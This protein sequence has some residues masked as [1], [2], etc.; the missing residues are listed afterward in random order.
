MKELTKEQ[1]IILLKI[2]KARITLAGELQR[3]YI[4]TRDIISTFLKDSE[5]RLSNNH[6]H[7]TNILKNIINSPFILCD[8]DNLEMDIKKLLPNILKTRYDLE[9]EELYS[10]YNNGDITDDELLDGKQMLKFCYYESSMDGKQIFKNG[11]VKS[12]VN[13]KI[14]CR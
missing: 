2:E 14:R 13:N 9:M 12:V 3:G 8:Q 7:K 1:H 5:Y 10:L 4:T 6:E 11:K